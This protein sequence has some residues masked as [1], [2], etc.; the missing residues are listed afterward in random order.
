M[1]VETLTLWRFALTL[2]RL[3]LTLWRFALTLWRF[4]LTAQSHKQNAGYAVYSLK[5]QPSFR[6]R[7][8]LRDSHR[9][10]HDPSRAP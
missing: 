9:V 10:P 5:P 3:A 1:G 6:F 7:R 8:R 2:W 4:A